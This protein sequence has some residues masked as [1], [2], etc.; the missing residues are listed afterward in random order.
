[1]KSKNI[2][3]KRKLLPKVL[4]VETLDNN[5]RV[6][7]KMSSIP[8]NWVF[9]H[10]ALVKLKD[11][12]EIL[13]KII[14]VD[15]DLK[16]VIA[17][18]FQ[19]CVYIWTTFSYRKTKTYK[20]GVVNFQSVECRLKETDT[21]GVAEEIE[22]V[23]TFPLY[24]ESPSECFK[25]E[26]EIHNNLPLV[27]KNREFV[28]AD[29]KKVI[30]PTIKKIIDKYR[31]DNIPFNLEI[32]TPRYYQHDGGNSARIHFTKNDRGW[33]QWFCRTGKTYGVFWMYREIFKEIKIKNN[34][35]LIF[36]PS[37][38]L[39][40]QTCDDLVGIA[41]L[42]GYNVKFIKIGKDDGMTTD[43]NQISGWLRETTIETLNIMVCTYHS[44]D[45]VSTATKTVGLTIDLVINDEAHKLAG[46]DN[47]SWKRCLKDSFIKR[48]KT[49]STTASP[50]EYVN[51]VIGFSGF[52]NEK[53][54][55]KKFHE[56]HFIDA[57]FDGVISPLR[58]L[59]IETSDVNVD[60][61]NRLIEQRRNIIQKNLYDFGQV[62]FNGIE[63][64]VDINQAR[65]TFFLQLDNTL[66]CL[67][68]GVF[69]HPIIQAN[70]IKTLTYF[71]ACLKALAPEYGVNLEYCELFTSENSNAKERE[72]SL[73]KLQNFKIGVVG[74]VYCF[75]EGITIPCADAIVMIDPRYSGP[76]I[77]QSCSRP[78]GLD[79]NNPDKIATFL[80][81]I[82][83]Q[84]NEEGKIIL[85]E[86]M[87]ST[88]RD[89]ILNICQTDED[90][91][92]FIINDLRFYTTKVKEATEVRN[93]VPNNSRTGLTGRIGNNRRERQIEEVDF[94]IISTQLKEM[95]STKNYVGK[96]QSDPD[97]FNNYIQNRS[98]STVLVYKYKIEEA[99][100]NYNSKNISKYSNLIKSEDE[101]INDISME[102]N[103]DIKEIN[104]LKESELFNE[105]I[106]LSKKLKDKNLKSSISLL[107]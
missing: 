21:T 31:A 35:I 20:I 29:L 66:S 88:T 16:C 106:T 28:R 49:L 86:S 11:G 18:K 39:V 10:H 72:R 76:N 22:H 26:K 96:T 65:Y 75:Q 32:P 67:R 93:V 48:R 52:E 62:D 83:L 69:T 81:P 17:K 9:E 68:D 24:I 95:S 100:K 103:I 34:I 30:I 47:K 79:K 59:G 38:Q 64:E 27:R 15:R 92:N 57:M 40:N 8:S 77:I 78:L 23:M 45:K 13:I 50:I 54:F 56:Y 55:G 73:N 70:S 36:V 43:E 94:G 14:E 104:F 3:T 91:K 46:N 84:K 7:L 102:L 87:W 101:Y 61:V 71:F 89:W 42:Y 74:N 60:Y 82:I 5:L 63:N 51:G 41:T 2:T 37:L 85:N 107:C 19:P 97:K 1:M 105:L 4:S 98:I 25:I 33:F 99:L 53:L 90:L 80:L 58:I 12:F 6:K 44:S